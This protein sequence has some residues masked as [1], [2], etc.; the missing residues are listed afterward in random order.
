MNNSVLAQITASPPSGNRPAPNWTDLSLFDWNNGGFEVRIGILWII[1]LALAVILFRMGWPWAKRKLV[2]GFRTKSVKLRFGSQEFEICPDHETRRIAYQAWVEIQT[3]KVGLAF[4]EQHD[5]IVEVYNSWFE[6]FRVLR[7]LAKT[8]PA[9]CLTDDEDA[10]KLVDIILTALNTGLR[11]HLTQWQ[12]KF[13]RWY[14]SAASK[15][16]NRDL[17]PQEIQKQYP[18]YTSL[19]QDLRQVNGEFV[20]FAESLL[21]LAEGGK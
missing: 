18:N 2:R 4:E 21:Q 11:P 5:V 8:I 15:E 12:A 9:E 17:S 16:E 19:V 1:I 13:R 10:R 14:A 6:L 20:R 7:E 3:R